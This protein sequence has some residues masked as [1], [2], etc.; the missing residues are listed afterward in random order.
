MT[1]LQTTNFGWDL[2]VA[3]EHENETPSQNVM[4]SNERNY[5]RGSRRE[6]GC[7]LLPRLLKS[8]LKHRLI[9]V[10]VAIVV[11]N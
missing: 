4:G 1:V 2:L 10:Q 11:Y 7:W 6:Q 3:G 5:L 9:T 8:V